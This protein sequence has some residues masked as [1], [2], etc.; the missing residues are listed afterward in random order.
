MVICGGYR[1]GKPDCGDIDVVLTHPDEEATDGF[2]REL[3]DVLEDE[4]HITHNLEIAFTNSKRGQNAVSWK[5]LGPKAGSGFDTLDHA[6]VLWQNPTWPTMEEDLEENP[7]AKNPNIHRR[8]DIIIS[9]WKTAGCAVIGWSGG[10]MFER[11]LRSYTRAELGYKFD[12]SGVR[13]VADGTWID[14][15]GDETDLLEKEKKVFRAL[16]LEWR[17]PTERCTD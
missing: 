4:G 17:E 10:T 14:L 7:N 8:V 5:G 9:P 11:D 3:V 13:S 16:K 15:E 1:R 2:L 6:F 12:S